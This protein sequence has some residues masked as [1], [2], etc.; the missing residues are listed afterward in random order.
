[1]LIKTPATKY[2][3]YESWNFRRI[4]SKEKRD[5]S[6]LQQRKLS[7]KTACIVELKCRSRMEAVASIDS[8]TVED[9]GIK[10]VNLMVNFLHCVIS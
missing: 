5:P 1:M 2:D 6:R 9:N 8:K 7:R 4:S 3:E 10:F